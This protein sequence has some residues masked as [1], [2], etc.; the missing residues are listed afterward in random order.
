MTTRSITFA[1]QEFYHVYN[2]GTDK[3]I[4]YLDNSDYVRFQE[5][6]YIAN[7]INPISFK[8]IKRSNENVYTFEREEELVAIGAYCL[9]PNH[10]H[11]LVTPLVDGGISTFMNKLT[12]GYSMY[13]NKKYTRTGRLFEGNFKSQHADT[14]EYLK[15]LFSYIHLNPVKLIQSNWKEIGIQ[16]ETIALNYSAAYAYSSLKDYLM[17]CRKE[18]VILNS[19]P[20]PKY[21]NNNTERK[22][23]LIEWLTYKG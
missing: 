5:L 20:F 1:P 12:T 18:G 13:F 19:Q 21:F 3:R 9:M 15:Y 7:T 14:D 11:I 4:I 8:D 23:E 17:D 2:R 16:N 6:L 22:S 10:F